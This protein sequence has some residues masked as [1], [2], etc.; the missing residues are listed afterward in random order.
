MPRVPDIGRVA[1]KWNQRAGNA[2][3]DYVDGVQ[4]PKADWAQA[5]AGAAENYKTGVTKAANEGRFARGVTKAGTQKQQ[6]ASIQKGAGRYAEGIAIAQ[7]DYSAAMEPVLQTI[8]ATSLPP[9]KPKGDP[10]NIN[11][12]AAIDA[13]L[14]QM[15]IGGRR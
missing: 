11:R 10:A 8:A 4:N 2:T 5:T 12:V 15:K 7:P 9:R 14:H 13:A 6:Q 3:N 1:A